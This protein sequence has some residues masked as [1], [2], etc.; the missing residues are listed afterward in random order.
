V[1]AIAA[2]FVVSCASS[3]SGPSDSSNGILQG[4][5][6]NAIDLS[7]IGGLSVQVGSK[8]AVTDEMG[9]FQFEIDPGTYPTV[10]RGAGIVD[11][12]TSVS[13]PSEN[14]FQFSLIPMS[15]D[16]AAF[17]EMV[18]TANG[19]LQRWTSRPSLIVLAS[20][21]TYR[22]GSG[23]DYNA[24]SEQMSDAEVNQ[25]VADL[26]EGLSLLTGQTY[27]SFASVT[28]E[29]PDSGQRVAVA[30]LGQIVVGEYNGIVSIAGTV[31]YGT[32]AET[33]EGSVVGGV[34]FL[35][36]DFDHND[37]RRRLLRIHEL[38]HALG[39]LHVTTRPSI[40]N[41]SIGPEPTDFDRAAAAIAFQRTPGNRSPDVDPPSTATSGSRSLARS[42]IRWVLP[43]E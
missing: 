17:D 4:Q 34:M 29:R 6:V 43:V 20:V 5:T 3:P 30:R 9:H 21:M 22:G 7:T 31:G 19:R 28:V 26:T 39:Y 38:G 37:G 11:R 1:L 24:T 27:T 14:A 32:W 10:I 25:M 8:H 18:R 15:F 12:Q 42:G 13:S 33:P 35:D 23:N 40:M 41:P 2:A 16:L 36:R